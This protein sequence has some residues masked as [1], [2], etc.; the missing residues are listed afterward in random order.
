MLALDGDAAGPTTTTPARP[1][2]NAAAIAGNIALVDRGTCG[3]TI[4]VKNAQNAGA[5]GVVVANNVGRPASGMAGADATITIPSLG[6]S[7]AHGDSDQG[8]AR[9]GTVER[10]A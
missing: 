9:G 3:F 5:S 8:G 7:N 2:T 10:D 1:L 4:K 6:I